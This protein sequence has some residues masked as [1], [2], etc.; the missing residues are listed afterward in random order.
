[1]KSLTAAKE[2]LASKGIELLV[3]PQIPDAVY[4]CSIEP[5]SISYQLPLE[6]A[7]AQLH[8]E[9]PSFRVS[10]DENT[11]QTVLGGMGKYE[12]NFIIFSF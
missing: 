8:R 6:K 7:L 9:D 12:T 11:M 3:K 2:K 4:F 1:M 5:P 10:Y